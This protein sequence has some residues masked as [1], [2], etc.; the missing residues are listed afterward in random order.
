MRQRVRFLF[1]VLVMA[2]GVAS[3]KG[4]WMFVDSKSG[5]LRVVATSQTLG[6][7]GALAKALVVPDGFTP[8]AM[9]G[10]FLAGW[11]CPGCG[12]G[13]EADWAVVDSSGAVLYRTRIGQWQLNHEG[14]GLTVVFP[15]PDW[16]DTLPL[17][18][19]PPSLNDASPKLVV[20]S[21]TLPAW[22]C[23]T[24][25]YNLGAVSL[26][27]F[28]PVSRG[29]VL[30]ICESTDSR[31]VARLQ[32]GRVVW[33]KNVS[34]WL[35]P[36][37]WDI[38]RQRQELLMG[39]GTLSTAVVLTLKDGAEAFRW[40]GPAA[41]RGRVEEIVARAHEEC[42]PRPANGTHPLPVRE[43]FP[44]DWNWISGFLRLE[45]GRILPSGELLLLGKD[46]F[47]GLGLDC[48]GEARL[49]RLPRA[50]D[51]ALRLCSLRQCLVEKRCE[52]AYAL[53]RRLQVG[54]GELYVCCSEGCGRLNLTFRH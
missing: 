42:R 2:A 8:V 39:D 36:Q 9:A 7:P 14:D 23:S 13:E 33:R 18:H 19:L 17:L 34:E 20:H 47:F 4:P 10:G 21:C 45:S 26:Q 11:L 27:G 41:L 1:P 43:G 12:E 22:E 25:T 6:H 35:A 29:D 50:G 16:K 30:V 44:A 5:Q 28:M 40:E 24:H 32:Q 46:A 37:L 31:F 53:E 38:N 3:A 48:G 51:D 52:K 49:L 15:L 54:E